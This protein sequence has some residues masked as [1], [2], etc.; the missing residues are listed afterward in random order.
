[1]EYNEAFWH[2]TFG[3]PSTQ[4]NIE[5]GYV[6]VGP[7]RVNLATVW[8]ID[9]LDL[10]EECNTFRMVRIGSAMNGNVCVNLINFLTEYRDVFT[11]IHAD[12]PG[13]D[14]E[15]ITHRLNINL[16]CRPVK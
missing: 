3:T 11:W 1:M 2:S 10:W 15:I 14:S 8:K 12:M 6:I 4:P 13:I 7:Y 16:R 5:K 9:E